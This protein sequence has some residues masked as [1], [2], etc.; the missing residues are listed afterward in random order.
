MSILVRQL[1]Q[2][3]PAVPWQGRAHCLTAE[4]HQEVSM[5]VRQLS[6]AAPAAPRLGQAHCLTAEEHQEV[7]SD[8]T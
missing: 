3:A 1:S 6:Q 5:L 7:M 2:A 8:M 4:E